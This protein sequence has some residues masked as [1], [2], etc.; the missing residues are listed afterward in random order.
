MKQIFYRFNIVL[1]AICFCLVA[2]CMIKGSVTTEEGTPLLGV[3]VELNGEPSKT[4]KTNLFGNY[5]FINISE[6]DYT[7]SVSSNS[8][9]FDN[10]TV[11]VS[12]AGNIINADFKV[13]RADIQTFDPILPND[14]SPC[15]D[16]ID[17]IKNGEA[18]KIVCFGD[19]L[20]YGYMGRSPLL[21][22]KNNYPDVLKSM[23]VEEL[24]NPNVEVVNMGNPGEATGGNEGIYPLFTSALSRTQDV[25]DM[26]PDLV[27]MMYGYNGRG[28]FTPEEMKTHW[29]T[30]I[31]EFHQA[32]ISVISMSGPPEINSNNTPLL[33]YYR[34]AYDVYQEEGTGYINLHSNMLEA[35]SFEELAILLPDNL[36]Y[37]DYTIMVETIFDEMMK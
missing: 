18:I 6:G 27:F 14:L 12:F 10:Y 30:I 7:V 20:T 11:D 5:R 2:G 21:K 34:V 32:G 23:I 26:E 35:L 36:H 13:T 25:I 28:L 15:K 16:V 8:Y 31:Q 9:T 33:P 1:I 29:K 4:T 24:G 37:S 22:V 19:S 3:T 17:R